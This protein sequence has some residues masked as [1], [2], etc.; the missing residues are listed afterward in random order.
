MSILRLHLSTAHD[1]SDPLAPPVSS[2][3]PY[4]TA[5]AR[6]VTG[7]APEAASAFAPDAARLLDANDDVATALRDLGAGTLVT[8]S[9]AQRG[10]DVTLVEEIGAGHKFAVRDL[11]A[12]V[13]IRKYGEFIGRVTRNVAAGE[14]VHVHNLVTSARRHGDDERAW[15]DQSGASAGVS[16]IGTPCTSVGESPVYDEDNAD[17]YWVDVRDTPAIH[18]ISLA[19]GVERSWPMREDVGSIAL[20][21]QGGLV[22]ALRSGFAF[23]DPATA[24]LK[25]IVDPEPERPMNR[26]NDGKCDAAGRFWCGSMNPDAGTADGSVYVLGSDLHCNRVLADFVTPNGMAWSPDGGTLYI[27]DTRRGYIYAHDFDPQSATL[28]ARRTFADTGSLPGGPDGATI[29]RDG[30]LWSA[31]WGGGALVRFDPRGRIERVVRLPVSKPTSCTFGGAGYRQLFVTTATR[32]ITAA[33]LSAE[34]LAG[35][36]LQL[37]VGVAGLAPARFDSRADERER[38]A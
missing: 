17:L 9:A 18:R 34:P 30:Y 27:A 13:R 23:F 7:V 35:R 6:A 25:P 8:L 33:Q 38:A 10:I 21:R 14:H 19:T 4:P 16:G 5:T 29:D 20:T 32:G 15:C 22:V 12:G 2:A 28:G 36:V 1:M 11:A 31:L 24:M 37:D 3:S 26:L